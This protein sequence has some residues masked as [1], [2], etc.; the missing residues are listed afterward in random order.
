[1]KSHEFSVIFANMLTGSFAHD[2]VVDVVS[3]AATCINDRIHHR[4]AAPWLTREQHFS[5]CE[6][7]Q[8]DFGASAVGS[9]LPLD[10]SQHF[11][12]KTALP[13][14]R[15]AQCR[16]STNQ[17]SEMPISVKQTSIHGVAFL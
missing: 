15:T 7:A 1:M 11:L 10:R 3:L 8:Q 6:R 5:R 13:T 2:P 4:A 12:S 17:S 14:T 16:H 9:S